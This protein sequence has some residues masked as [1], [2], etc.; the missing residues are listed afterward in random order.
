[1]VYMGAVD[2]VCE[3]EGQS[4]LPEAEEEVVIVVPEALHE[5]FVEPAYFGHIFGRKSGDEA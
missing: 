4:C 3:G 1:M 5:G 2:I